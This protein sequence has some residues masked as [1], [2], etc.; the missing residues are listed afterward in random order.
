[1]VTPDEAYIGLPEI[2]GGQFRFDGKRIDF[3]HRAVGE[4]EKLVRMW[5]PSTGA[6]TLP[7]L[8]VPLVKVSPSELDERLLFD[9][10]IPSLESK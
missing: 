4:L 6:K 2:R 5:T 7:N 10:V 8:G 3:Q 9:H 1:M